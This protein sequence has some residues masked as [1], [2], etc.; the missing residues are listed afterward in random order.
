MLLGVG[1]DPH[2]DEDHTNMDQL[3]FCSLINCVCR[4]Y[5]DTNKKNQ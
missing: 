4:Q 1:S 3:E 2:P 5:N